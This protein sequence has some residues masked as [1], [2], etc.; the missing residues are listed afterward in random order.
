MLLQLPQQNLC[1]AAFRLLL[2][3]GA[4]ALQHGAGGERTAPGERR[5]HFGVVTAR[6]LMRVRMREPGGR[7][8]PVMMI[9]D[10]NYFGCYLAEPEY[11]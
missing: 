8:R 10:W 9:C 2:L 1:C 6:F 5:L 3:G 4:A 11:D 7:P